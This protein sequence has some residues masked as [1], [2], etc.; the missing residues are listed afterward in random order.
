MFTVI[1]KRQHQIITLPDTTNFAQQ[2]NFKKGGICSECNT[3]Q[4]TLHNN[5]D[6]NSINMSKNTNKTKNKY[7]QSRIHYTVSVA[8]QY[9]S[10]I[11]SVYNL[12]SLSYLINTI[13][14]SQVGSYSPQN[15]RPFTVTVT[16]ITSCNTKNTT[17]VIVTGNQTVRCNIWAQ[18]L[19]A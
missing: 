8:Y 15:T 16:Q 13:T 3:N 4:F 2:Y 12:L 14:G 7:K 1:M 19:S 18:N 9:Q 6:I 11:S 17:P 5:N 10:C